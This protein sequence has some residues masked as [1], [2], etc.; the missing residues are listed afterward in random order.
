M[1]KKTSADR[2]M[3]QNATVRFKYF[4]RSD[5]ERGAERGQ[6]KEESKEEMSSSQRK[7]RGDDKAEE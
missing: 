5:P 6:R 3:P 7:K 4:F 1:L 2:Q